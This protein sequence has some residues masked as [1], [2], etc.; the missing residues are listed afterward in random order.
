MGVALV[1]GPLKCR[2]PVFGRS[3][4]CHCYHGLLF[5]R[6]QQ[7]CHFPQIIKPSATVLTARKLEDVCRRTGGSGILL[8]D[9]RLSWNHVSRELL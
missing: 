9:S 3:Y 1:C 4:T 7:V 2:I 8:Y 6:L 5:S